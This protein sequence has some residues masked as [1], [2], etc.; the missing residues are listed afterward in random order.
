MHSTEA[1]H[2]TPAWG[3]GTVDLAVLDAD[4]ALVRWWD[5]GGPRLGVLDAVS[6]ET[7]PVDVEGCAFDSLQAVGDEVALRRGLVDRLPEVVRGPLSGGPAR[8]R[9]VR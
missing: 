6:G 5:G 2:A 3:L 8:P 9:P 1:D 7:T 4:R